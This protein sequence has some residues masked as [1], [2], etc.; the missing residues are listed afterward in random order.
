[1]SGDFSCDLSSCLGLSYVDFDECSDERTR[2]ELVTLLSLPTSLE[3]GRY[4]VTNLDFITEENGGRLEKLTIGNNSPTVNNV[5]T[6]SGIEYATNLVELVFKRASRL[7]DVREAT[8]CSNLARYVIQGVMDSSV[9]T[10]PLKCFFKENNMD[11]EYILLNLT[12]LEIYDNKNITNLVGLSDINK[13][14]TLKIYSTGISDITGLS[15]Q[16]SLTTLQLND[17]AISDLTEIDNLIDN[18]TNGKVKFTS[19]DLS[20]NSIGYYGKNGNDNAQTILNLYNAGCTSIN[21]KGN[22]VAESPKLQNIA[23]IITE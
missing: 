19:L 13:L 1:M 20:D 12:D 23:G 2:S 11:K 21:V 22:A 3:F 10:I 17:N 6:L 5:Q 8:K 16:T 9:T 15:N 18:C 14:T 7:R 4:G